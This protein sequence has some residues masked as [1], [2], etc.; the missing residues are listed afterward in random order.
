MKDCFCFHWQRPLP[1]HMGSKY[2]KVWRYSRSS[3]TPYSRGLFRFRGILV[4][5][6]WWSLRYYK[7]IFFA[8]KCTWTCATAKSILYVSYHLNLEVSF[9]RDKMFYCSSSPPKGTL[10]F[11]RLYFFSQSSTESSVAII[12]SFLPLRTV[13]IGGINAAS[14]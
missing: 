6:S 8:L 11:Q 4:T 2:S 1:R 13:I 5:K 9:W 7:H 14:N 12:L 3:N 10:P